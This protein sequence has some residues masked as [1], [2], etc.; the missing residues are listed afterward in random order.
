MKTCEIYLITPNIVNCEIN[1]HS[2]KGQVLLALRGIKINFPN[3]NSIRG[4]TFEYLQS[5]ITVTEQMPMEVRQQFFRIKENL[6]NIL[7][8]LITQNF[9]KLSYVNYTNNLPY[10]IIA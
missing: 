7:N 9:I 3:G 10:G 1:P 8:E 6:K 5:T 4:S 2:D